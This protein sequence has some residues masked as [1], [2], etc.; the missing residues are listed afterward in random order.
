MWVYCKR[1]NTPLWAQCHNN[2][3]RIKTQKTIDIKVIPEP[4]ITTASGSTYI[5]M[6]KQL[7]ALHNIQLNSLYYPAN[8]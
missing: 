5:Y 3:Y 6:H 8:I 2:C 7:S 4:A 1:W